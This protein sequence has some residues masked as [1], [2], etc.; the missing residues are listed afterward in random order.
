MFTPVDIGLRHQNRALYGFQVIGKDIRNMVNTGFQGIGE[1]IN[2]Q[3]SIDKPAH[4]L[5]RNVEAV[6]AATRPS[7]RPSHPQMPGSE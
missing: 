1:G 2:S 3:T 5:Y 6:I 4:N 7:L